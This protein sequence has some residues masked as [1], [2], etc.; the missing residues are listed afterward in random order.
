MVAA[1]VG[2]GSAVAGVAGANAQSNAAQAANQNQT[3]FA[4]YSAINQQA[5]LNNMLALL[6]PYVDAGTTAVGQQRD[7]LGLNG[8]DAQQSFINNLQSSPLFQS[9][10]KQGEQSILA[11]ASATGG[12]RGGNTQAAL[13]QFSPAMLSAEINNRFQ[14]LGGLVNIGQNAAVQ[15]G[16][17]GQAATNAISSQLAQIGASRAGSAIAQGRATASG[18]GA[19][20]SGLGLWAGGRSGGGGSGL[21]TLGSGFGGGG[22][23]DELASYGVF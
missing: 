8:N 21:S 22:L 16:N 2:V 19:I 14:Q 3:E 10:V 7:I 23:M 11:N 13:A 12:L 4:V 20:S 9:Q 5:N 17:A 18:L 15:S 1:A 6:R